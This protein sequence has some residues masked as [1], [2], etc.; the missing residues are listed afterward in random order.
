LARG[1]SAAAGSYDRWAAPQRLAAERLAGLIPAPSDPRS[2]LD[3][4]CGTGA[5]L[6]LLYD[7]FPRASLTGIDV[8]D[9][10]IEACRRSF[11]G[12][13]RLSFITADVADFAPPC[14]F[15]LIASNFCL[16]WTADPAQAI[17]RLGGMFA[18]KG[19]L[20]LAVPVE[21]SLPELAES[22]RRAI[23]VEMG[24]PPMLAPGV[25]LDAI[26]RAGLGLLRHEV[27]PLR[28]WFESGL[29]V[30]RHFRATGTTLRH[31]P[32]HRPRSAAQTRRL[33]RHYER[34]FADS[35]GRVPLTFRVLY[36]VAQPMA[37]SS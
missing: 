23:G 8:A 37:G 25:Y 4:G 14:P 20:A 33:V 13:D 24:G 19:L 6:R 34:R 17:V 35:A 1:F 27:G 36:V 26:D 12:I 29:D 10:M 11:A 21:G 32:G 2:I 3:A 22:Y 16:H 18:P 31:L 15:D 9:G 30:L 7:R 5:L 28:A